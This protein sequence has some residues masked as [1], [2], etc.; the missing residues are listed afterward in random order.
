[1]CRPVVAR[2]RQ[3]AAGGIVQV[4][5]ERVLVEVLVWL[6]IVHLNTQPDVNDKLLEQ[7]STSMKHIEET[8]SGVG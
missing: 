5:T 3:F 4:S 7:S 6:D 2:F 8:S 1:M